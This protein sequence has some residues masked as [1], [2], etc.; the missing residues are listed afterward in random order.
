[1]SFK[2]YMNDIDLQLEV[3]PEKNRLMVYSSVILVLVSFGYYFFGLD[4]QDEFKEKEKTLLSLEKKLADNKISLYE[5]K[6]SQA[7]KKILFL[8]KEYEDTQYKQT[9]LQVKLE[10]M[11]YLS[12][13]AKGLADILDRMLK[14]SVYLGVNIQKIMV[15]KSDLEYKAYIKEKGIIS[16]EGTASFRSVLKLLRFI[17]SQEALIEIKNVHF[18]LNDA[19]S[20]PAFVIMIIGYGISV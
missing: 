5:D 20:K 1:M 14:E 8:A 3:M 2:D 18:E 17:E 12:S 11:D 6:I 16:I 9:S 13:D 7:R 19:Q 10:R 15:D 4:L